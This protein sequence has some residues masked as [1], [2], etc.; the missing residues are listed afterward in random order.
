MSRGVALRT[1]LGRHPAFLVNSWAC[2]TGTTQ[3]DLPCPTGTLARLRRAS[4]AHLRTDTSKIFPRQTLQRS[5]CVYAIADD[6]SGRDC[7]GCDRRGAPI[8]GTATECVAVNL[9]RRE[10]PIAISANHIKKLGLARCLR[11]LHGLL[12]PKPR[13]HKNKPFASKHRDQIRV[14]LKYNCPKHQAM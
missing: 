10:H 9:R 1:N 7:Q 2:I 4:H 3:P 12:H 8:H 11:V 5:A 13:S 14:A 6:W